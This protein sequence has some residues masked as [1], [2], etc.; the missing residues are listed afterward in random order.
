MSLGSFKAVVVGSGAGGAP[1]AAALAEAWGDGVALV[2]AGRSWSAGEF[3]QLEA[4]MLP[5]LYA[6]GGLQATEDGAFTVLQ[7]SCV[8][9]STVVNDA[10]CFRPPPE[11]APRW[12]EYGVDLDMAE[13]GVLADEVERAMGATEIP[14]AMINRANYLL[15]LGAARLGWAGE[16]LRHNSPGCLQCGFRSLG[17]AYDAKRSMNLAF[18]PQ[19]VA[20]GCQLM[21]ETPVTHLTRQAGKWRVHTARGTLDAEH[22]VLAAGVVQ[23]PAILLRSGMPAGE[24]LQFH[25]QAI[26]WGDFAEPVNGFDGIPMATGVMEFS[27]VYGHTGPGYLIEGVS[28]GPT[29]GLVM[30]PV[31]GPAHAE[32]QSRYAHL[33]G[34]VSLIRSKAR[35]KV[36]LGPGDRPRIHYPLVDADIARLAHFFERGTELFLAAGAKRVMTCHRDQPWVTAPPTDLDIAPGRQYLYTAHPFGGACRGT[37]TDSVGRVLEQDGLW[38]LDGSAIPEAVGVNPQVT[39]ASLALQGARRILA[40]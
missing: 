24:G 32:V 10:L 26:V 7:G 38:V 6:G 31:Q 8:G 36:D 12:A 5:A 4:D 11:L 35:G 1:A 34:G 13:M 40:G 3:N 14:R 17:C 23:T 39:I 19:A 28:Y 2:E 9:G 16:R 37:T 27:D 25:V 33:A 30:A 29:G 21:P 15:L 18:V 22:V 20:S